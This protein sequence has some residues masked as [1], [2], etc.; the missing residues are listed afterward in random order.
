MILLPQQSTS[1]F[2]LLLTLS[3]ITGCGASSGRN[4]QS[5]LANSRSSH[6]FSFSVSPMTAQVG[7]GDSQQFSALTWRRR[8]PAVTWSVDGIP[9]GNS[10]VGT[11]DSQGLYTAPAVLPN[12]SFV[13]VTATL[14]DSSLSST[15]RLTLYK[16]KLDRGQLAV[17]PT[18]MSFGSVTIGSSQSQTGTLTAGNSSVTVSTASWNGTGFSLTGISFPVII[19]AGQKIPFTVTFTPQSAGSVPGTISFLSNSTN[20]PTNAQL[21]GSGVAPTPYT[22]KLSWS[23]SSSSIQG[24]N[25]YRGGQT[26][27]PYTKISRLQPSTGYIDSAVASGQNYYYVVTAVGT[28]S[29]ES[30][31]SNEFHAVIPTP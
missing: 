17:T 19:P 14:P 28:D 10:T 4:V 30:N 5:S 25:V 6:S 21:D 8:L 13:R 27:G 23:T 31:Y 1:C 18:S 3:L 7:T 20:S 16:Y 11:I 12:P 24:Y 2:A 29:F 22:V 15:A 9:G 26:G